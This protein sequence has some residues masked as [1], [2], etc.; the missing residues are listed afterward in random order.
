LLS[1]ELNHIYAYLAN[2]FAEIV[3]KTIGQYIIALKIERI[4]E[5]ILFGANTFS[6]IADMLHYC[7]VAQFYL[8]SLQMQQVLHLRTLRQ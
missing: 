5:L 4:K 3:A 2:F 8:P 7:S 1:E 6:E